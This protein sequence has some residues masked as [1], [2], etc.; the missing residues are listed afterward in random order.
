MFGSKSG[1]QINPGAQQSSSIGE[2]RREAC[3]LEKLNKG[4][5]AAQKAPA[6]KLHSVEAIPAEQAKEVPAAG[7]MPADEP[8]CQGEVPAAEVPQSDDPQH[9]VKEPAAVAPQAEEFMDI[10]PDPDVEY[11]RDQALDD[12]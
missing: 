4:E 8:Q 12:I 10:Q 11:M 6:D 3:L 1:D 5:P 2:A 7:K 9:Q